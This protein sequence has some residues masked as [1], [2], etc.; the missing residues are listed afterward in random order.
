MPEHTHQVM[1]SSKSPDSS[2]PANN[3]W[4]SNTGFNAYSKTINE[5]M[6][7]GNINKSGLN[8][9]HSNMPPYLVLN[10]CIALQGIFPSQN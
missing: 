2:S 4:A 3:T 6:L 10:F 5:A 7:E 1:A 9:A 8:Q